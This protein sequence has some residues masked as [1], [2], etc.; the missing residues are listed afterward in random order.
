MTN[1]YIDEDGNKSIEMLWEELIPEEGDAGVERVA[2][3]APY[4]LEADARFREA[5]KRQ[6]EKEAEQ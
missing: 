4:M 1:R 6:R 3:N 2:K 5:L